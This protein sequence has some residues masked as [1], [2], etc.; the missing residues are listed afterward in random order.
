MFEENFVIVDIETTGLSPVKNEIIEIGALKVE[1]G[2][3]IDRMDIFLKP[4]KGVPY[5]ITNLTGI[6]NEMV[7]DGYSAE[8]GMKLFL[9]FSHGYPLIAHNA[10][11]DISFLN[12]YANLCFQKSITNKCLDTLQISKSIIK[13]IPNYKLGTLAQYFDVNYIGAHRALKDCE[14]TLEVYNKLNAMYHDTKCS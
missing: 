8:E 14:I 9:E 13:D 3:I 11:F 7:K 10:K 6:T 12:N 1:N 2:E 4:K 5:F